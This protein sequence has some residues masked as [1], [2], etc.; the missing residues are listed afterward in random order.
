MDDRRVDQ[1]LDGYDSYDSYENCCCIDVDGQCWYTGSY[2]VYHVIS[3]ESNKHWV[4]VLVTPVAYPTALFEHASTRNHRV[5]AALMNLRRVGFWM[6]VPDV[7][8]E[9]KQQVMLGLAAEEEGPSK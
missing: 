4:T 6:E 2:I 3:W 7:S 5:I 9:A 8:T 1:I